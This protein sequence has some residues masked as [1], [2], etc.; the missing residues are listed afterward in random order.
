MNPQRPS[1][2]AVFAVFAL[3]GLLVGCGPLHVD[4]S[5][6]TNLLDDQTSSLE[7]GVGQWTDWYSARIA[8][9]AAAAR[10]GASGLRIAVTA[11][12]GWGVTLDNWPGFRAGEGHHRA[13][14]WARSV[15]GDRITTEM[16]ITWRNPAGGDLRK[17]SLFSPVLGSQWVKSALE[18]VAPAGTDRVGVDI[19]GVEGEVD[20]VIDVDAVYLIRSP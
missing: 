12:Y 7:G 8:S 11:Q 10:V 20:D 5:P 13:T 16:R 6:T 18:T 4:H 19:V 1:V 14:F 17:D 15:R 2:F 9:D 3:L